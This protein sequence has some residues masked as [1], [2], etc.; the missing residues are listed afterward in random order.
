MGYKLSPEERRRY[1]EEGLVIPETSLSPQL[2]ARA[3]SAVEA[4][5]DDN[6]KV[7]RE[8]TLV[9]HV[10]PRG[11]NEGTEG[12]ELIFRIATSEE[13]L[14]LV[15]QVLGPDIILWGSSIFAK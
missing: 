1:E 7:S 9:A 15:E 4:M 5:I 8:F 13:V 11:D 14:D 10:P 12:A 6:G 2:F 3:K